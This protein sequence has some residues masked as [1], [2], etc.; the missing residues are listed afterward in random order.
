MGPLC[1][2]DLRFCGPQPEHGHGDS[3]SRGV[4]AYFPAE[5]DT[6]LPTPEGWKAESTYY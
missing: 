5:T 4:H 1:G 3:A 2:P 6:H